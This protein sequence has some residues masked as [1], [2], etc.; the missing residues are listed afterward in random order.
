[1]NVKLQARAIRLEY[2]QSRTNSRIVALDGV[3]L[4]V[5]EGDAERGL[6]LV[7]GAV[8]GPT[9]SLVFVRN[10]TKAAVKR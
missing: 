1:M 5:V 7:K 10:A 8:P 2:V 4:E 6:L 9:G 3:N